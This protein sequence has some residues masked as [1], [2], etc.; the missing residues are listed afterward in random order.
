MVQR[1]TAQPERLRL[2]R[3]KPQHGGRGVE[4]TRS[5]SMMCRACGLLFQSTGTYQKYC[6]PCGIAAKKL[7]HKGYMFA[8]AKHPGVGKGHAQGSGPS[9]HSYINGATTFTQL[10]LASMPTWSCERCD[11]DL[12]VYI[13]SGGKNGMWCVHHKDRDRTHNVIENLELLCKRCHQ[14]E[15]DCVSSL[16][17]RYSP[18]PNES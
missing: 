17:R 2:W 14:L 13:N 18:T 9:H 10:K 5:V 12:T 16:P 6:P 15:H 7:R 11:V 8:K 1:L 4:M 3:R